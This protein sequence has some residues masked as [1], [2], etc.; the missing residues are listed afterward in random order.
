LNLMFCCLKARKIYS[1]NSL[2]VN[3]LN[4]QFT[5]FQAFKVEAAKK[6]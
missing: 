5:Y 2:M 3:L 6:N 4:Q 1:K